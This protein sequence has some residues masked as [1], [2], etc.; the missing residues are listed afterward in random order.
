MQTLRRALVAVALPARGEKER[1][2]LRDM[3]GG[4]GAQRRQVLPE[5]GAQH[6]RQQN[7]VQKSARRRLKAARQAL[8]DAE[9]EERL[10]APGLGA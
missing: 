10:E 7:H 6:Q 3:R 9:D 8:Q 1:H 2:R 4:L 5:Q